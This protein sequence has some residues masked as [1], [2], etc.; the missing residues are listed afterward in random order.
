MKMAGMMHA[1][2]MVGYLVG[3]GQFFG[4]LGLLVG[5]FTRIAAASLAIIMLGA[6]FLVHLP[7]GFDLSHGGYEYAFSMFMVA[8][9]LVLTGP[10]A[11]SLSARLS[12]SLKK[13]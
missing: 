5:L 7:H 11:Y 13:L 4:G 12:P 3:I 6:I 10:G 9:A 2:A 8:L 1:P